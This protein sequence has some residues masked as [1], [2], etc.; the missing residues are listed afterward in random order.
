MHYLADTMALVRHLRGG[1]GLGRQARKILRESDQGH[2]TIA[3]SGVTLMEI[4]YL[5]ERKRIPVDLDT[6]GNL[7]AQSSNYGVVPVDFQVVKSAA[8]IDDV[9]ELHDRLI[10]G[11][12]TWLGIPMLTS[13]PVMMASQHVQTI[14]K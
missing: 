4:L 9:P 7:L 2:H 11:T 12:A 6:L 10:A 13:D 14:W 8:A 3:I 5:F 1:R